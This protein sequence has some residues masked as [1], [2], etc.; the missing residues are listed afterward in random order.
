MIFDEVICNQSGSIVTPKRRARGILSEGAKLDR[1]P[2][3]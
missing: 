1:I 2:V 3:E